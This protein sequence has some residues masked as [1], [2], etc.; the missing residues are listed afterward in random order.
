[1][2]PA[3]GD[4]GVAGSDSSAICSLAQATR[5]GRVSFITK[6]ESA[7]RVRSFLR[8][9]RMRVRAR[10]PRISG[11]SG[12]MATA[13]KPAELIWTVWMERRPY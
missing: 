12:A 6:S 11:L 10:F 1:M 9:L 4:S 2:V 8:P 5:S 7:W 3:L 13:R